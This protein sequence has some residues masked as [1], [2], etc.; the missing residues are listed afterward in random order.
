VAL[1]VAALAVAAWAAA[2]TSRAVTRP[3]GTLGTAL[4]AIGG[5]DLRHGAP[6]PPAAA[7][8]EALGAEVDR[9]RERLR[10]L[11]ARVQEEADQVTAAAGELAANAT[12]TASATQHVTGAVLEISA[13]AAVQL[14]ALEDADLAVRAVAARGDAIGDAAADAEHAGREIRATT[15]AARARIGRAVDLLLGAR[16]TADASVRELEALRDAAGVADGF[17]A[18]IREIAGQTHLLALNA[19]LEAAR[20]G[21]AGRGFAV[22]ADEVRALAEQSA[23]AAEEVTGNVQRVRARLA[24][25]VAAVDAGHA[26]LRDA[27]GVAEGAS[28]ALARVGAAAA[29]VSESAE[30][31]A[32]A[33]GESRTATAEAE[34]AIAR[35]R[36]AAARHAT[37]AE[38]VAAA[39][40]QTAA[41]VEEVSATAEQL[42][43]GASAVRGL[44][45]GFRT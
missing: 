14:A 1:L 22:V 20:A 36:D 35:A 10:E 8:Y 31:V 17:A 30:R 2:A 7:E 33:V 32:G 6:R 44:V 21:R 19:A 5:G 34:T 28:E 39:T 43:A 23:A 16:E 45:G 4:G 24:G 12:G 41:S 9:A 40:E 42:A 38:E 25:A 18:V 29:R 15:H 26:R 13:G 11:L 37:S 27:E 3:L